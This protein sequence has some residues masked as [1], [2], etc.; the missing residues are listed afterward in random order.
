MLKG[1]KLQAKAVRLAQNGLRPAQIAKR[2]GRKSGTIAAALSHARSAGI[3]VP[4]CRP[5]IVP[6]SLTSRRLAANQRRDE[7]I[8]MVRMGLRPVEIA[9]CIGCATSTVSSTLS[10][11][12]A[13]GSD[14]P[15]ARLGRPRGRRSAATTPTPT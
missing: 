1:F 6:G 7:M 14:L 8:R 3:A 5:G 9:L 2:L 4:K 10:R 15:H 11:L 12:R 13:E